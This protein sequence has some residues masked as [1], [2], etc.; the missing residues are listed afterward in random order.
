MKEILLI[1]KEKKIKMNID[2]HHSNYPTVSIFIVFYRI[3]SDILFQ[4]TKVDSFYKIELFLCFYLSLVEGLHVCHL[5]KVLIFSDAI[6]IDFT[7]VFAFKA[8]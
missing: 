2:V 4:P 1:S 7:S 3:K 8:G 6:A 5:S